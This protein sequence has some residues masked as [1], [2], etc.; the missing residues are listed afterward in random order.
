[1]KFIELGAALAGSILGG[2]LGEKIG[3]RATLAAAGC[4]CLL[5]TLWLVFS[6]V[7][8]LRVEADPE[9]ELVG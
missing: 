5:S 4:G 6:P 7:R 1:M 2:L 3:V 9:L 8:H